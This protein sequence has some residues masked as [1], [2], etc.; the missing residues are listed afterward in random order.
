MTKWCCVCSSYHHRL[1]KKCRAVDPAFL[2]VVRI[3]LL[4]PLD[5]GEAMVPL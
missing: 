5:A 2:W 4:F 1:W 3:R